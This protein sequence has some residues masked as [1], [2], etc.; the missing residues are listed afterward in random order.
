MG[1]HCETCHNEIQPSDY[2]SYD[3]KKHWSCQSVMEKDRDIEKRF[4]K[5]SDNQRVNLTAKKSGKLP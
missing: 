3:G 5:K 2:V 4:C 1:K